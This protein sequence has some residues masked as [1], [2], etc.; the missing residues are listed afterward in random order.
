ML[1]EDL[2][3]PP[4]D[5]RAKGLWQPGPPIRASEFVAAGHRLF[6]GAV[7]WPALVARRSALHHNL[8][9]MADFCARHGFS[10]APHGKTTMAP[11]L[12]A[13]QLAGGAWAITVATANQLLVCRHLGVPRVLLANQLLDPVP[14]R[15]LAGELDRGFEAYLFVDSVAGVEAIGT[16]LADRPDGPAVRVLA[17]LGHAG[18]RTGCRTIRQLVEVAEA[19]ADTARVRLDGVTAYEGGLRDATEVATYLDRTR[20]ATVE[21]AARGLLPDEVIVSA[22]GSAWF[23]VVADRLGGAWLPG[24]HLRVVLR[25]GA[26]VSHDHGF[27][28][29]HTPF[30]RSPEDGSLAGAL[31]LWAQ[32]ISTPE[33]GLAIVAMGKRDAPYDEGL[34]VPLRVR[35]ASGSVTEVTGVT[36]TR[37]NDH[38]AFL[39]APPDVDL[40]PG[41]LVC[42]GI[43][44]PCTAFDKWRYIPVLDD[45]DTVVDVLH[46][47]F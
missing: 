36:V 34:P 40:H 14:L 46:T 26:Y 2:D 4:L 6:D 44:H 25:S 22:G 47:Y 29:A 1:R 19:V 35:R 28:A 37:L 30:R 33:P 43:S 10:F 3:E 32:V 7:S 15:W 45:T 38:H 41:D 5:W 23:D 24:R 12:F 42:F 17:E 27:Y 9:T 21:L 31:E 11:S 18:G 20:E 8:T 39:A 16:T 13:A